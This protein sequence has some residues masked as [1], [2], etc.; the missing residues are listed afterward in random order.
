VQQIITTIKKQYGNDTNGKRTATLVLNPG[1]VHRKVE[2]VS[3]AFKEGGIIF[4][5]LKAKSTN[6]LICL[7]N[8]QK[9]YND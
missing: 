5:T 9:I 8:M 3:G 4:L 2:S 1:T 7:D 6:S